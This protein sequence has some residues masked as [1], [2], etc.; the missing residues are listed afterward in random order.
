MVGCVCG[1]S[2]VLLRKL[3]IY[4]DY[5]WYTLRATNFYVPGLRY[6]KIVEEYTSYYVRPIY[7]QLLGVE[8]I[9][10]PRIKLDSDTLTSTTYNLL[11]Y[12]KEIFYRISSH[13][14]VM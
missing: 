8:F 9:E 5:L 12:H 11:T 13:M 7:H 4:C 6:G 2:I 3:A 10:F 1:P 14:P